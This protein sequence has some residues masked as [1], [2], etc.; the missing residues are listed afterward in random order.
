M[1]SGG[2]QSNAR[3]NITVA[4]TARSAAGDARVKAYEM[5]TQN[6]SPGCDA[7]PSLATHAAMA[8]ELEIELKAE[9]GW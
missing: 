2:M 4:V 8:A 6:P 5:T 1:L 7:H 3:R 9:L